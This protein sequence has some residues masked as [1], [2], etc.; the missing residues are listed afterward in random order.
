MA[1]LILFVICAA[2]AA[3]IGLLFARLDSEVS[4]LDNG[5]ARMMGK[6]HELEK[7]V[8]AL[9]QGEVPDY[10]KAKEAAAAM[11]EFASGL[12]G[13][14]GYDPFKALKK[15]NEEQEA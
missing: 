4:I 13:I 2:E 5:S 7:K 14:F 11:N 6:I 8:S 15:K 9:E 3:A 1:I 12:S 10:R